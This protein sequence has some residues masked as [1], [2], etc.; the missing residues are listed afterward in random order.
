MF[1]FFVISNKLVSI[2]SY[3]QPV[4]HIKLGIKAKPSLVLMPS[5]VTNP[6]KRMG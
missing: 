3:I 1:F 6:G 5:D 4:F 2:T